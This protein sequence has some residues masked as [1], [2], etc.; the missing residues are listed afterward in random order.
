M[1][2]D[3]ALTCREPVRLDVNARGWTDLSPRE[4]DKHFRAAD[5]ELDEVG[6]LVIANALTRAECDE[7]YAIISEEASTS[8]AI[9]QALFKDAPVHKVY[10]F[11]S[12]HPKAMELIAYPFLIEY[13]RR[14][15]GPGMVI[16]ESEAGLTPPGSSG[17]SLHYDG[18]DRIPDYYLGINCIYYLVDA[19][20]SNG[21]TR[22]IPG[23]HKEF[24][25]IAEA[26]T[27]EAIYVSVKKGD[28]VVFNPYLMH[29]ASANSS[30][31]DR[32]VIIN[33]YTRGFVRQRWDFTRG[34][35]IAQLKHLSEDQKTLL[36]YRHR[37]MR[38]V[39]ELYFIKPT[40]GEFDPL[41]GKEDRASRWD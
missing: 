5:R 34:I 37:A 14:L 31:N 11:Q 22:Y 23:T 2:N 18:F 24:I 36:G 39:S 3:D 16:H 21:A 13:L 20:K 17:G 38:D 33:L 12:R 27:R 6:I 28:L 40:V 4:K 7:F 35:P 9:E 1:P 26:E 8:W 10:D 30:P 32:P 29:G 15:L 19:D 41:Y 25:D